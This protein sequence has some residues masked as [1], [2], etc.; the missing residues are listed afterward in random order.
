MVIEVVSPRGPSHLHVAYIQADGSVVH[1]VQSDATNLQTVDSGRRLI[2][3]DGLEGRQRFVVNPPFGAEL[4][5]ALASR[6]PLFPE[7]RPQSETERD[8][9][10]ALRKALLWKPDVMAPDREVSAAIAAIVT[11]EK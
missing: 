11:T 4:I 8:F 9:L 10:T 6:A 3:G 7:P 1:L 5:I 2:F